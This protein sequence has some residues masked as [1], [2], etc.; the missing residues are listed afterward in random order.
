MLVNCVFSSPKS[1]Q[2]ST[3]RL[4]N[5]HIWHLYFKSILIGFRKYSNILSHWTFEFEFVPNVLPT[6]TWQQIVVQV[7]EWKTL[8]LFAG[9]ESLRKCF[10]YF[11]EIEIGQHKR[12]FRSLGISDNVIKSKDPLEYED[13][14]H[15]LLNIWVEKE[16]REAS[17]NHLLK[18]LLD[19]NQRRTAETVREKAIVGGHYKCPSESEILCWSQGEIVFVPMAPCKI[20]NIRQNILKKNGKYVQMCVL[21]IEMSI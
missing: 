21:Y 19:L 5:W 4:R 16:G 9:E 14:I 3:K 12:F 18:A 15:D 13:K 8:S 2:L 10:E 11:E 20:R 7:L 1:P 6:M 17:L